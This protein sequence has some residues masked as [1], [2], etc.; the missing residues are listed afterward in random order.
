M[1]TRKPRVYPGEEDKVPGSRKNSPQEKA[2]F[3]PFTS[4]F[5]FVP[6]RLTASMRDHL[7][8][9]PMDM[10]LIDKAMTEV[11]TQGYKLTFKWDDYSN[12]FAAFMMHPSPDHEN[13]LMILAGRGST[14]L[15]AARQL[16]F[17]HFE[18]WQEEW[19]L[20]VSDGEYDD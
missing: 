13:A 7:K 6:D 2:K 20:S 10:G 18:V 11:L 16:F 4:Q 17:L 14:P 3:T 5:K 15:K 9:L 8:G 12:S 19:A 1:T